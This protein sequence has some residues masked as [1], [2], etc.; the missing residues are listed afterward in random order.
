MKA[1][2]NGRRG[3]ESMFPMQ[4]IRLSIIP[5]CSRGDSRSGG[6]EERGRKAVEETSVQG[7]TLMANS[8]KFAGLCVWQLQGLGKTGTNLRGRERERE[9]ERGEVV[10]EQKKS[11]IK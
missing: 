1:R 3:K 2:E 11:E 6:D 4:S 9:G 5:C 8:C 10:T 7:G